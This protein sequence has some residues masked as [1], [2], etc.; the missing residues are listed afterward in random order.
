MDL[1]MKL[2]KIKFNK[3]LRIKIKNQTLRVKP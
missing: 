3:G 1:R 2:K